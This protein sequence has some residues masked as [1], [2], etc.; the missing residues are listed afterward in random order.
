[1]EAYWDNSSPYVYFIFL[2]LLALLHPF[3][4][5]EA[6][7]F[8]RLILINCLP[9]ERLVFLFAWNRHSYL[10][11]NTH[12]VLPCFCWQVLGSP[13]QNLPTN[14]LA[15]K[16]K[17]RQAALRQNRRH[18]WTASET[19]VLLKSFSIH[20]GGRGLGFEMDCHSLVILQVMVW[21]YM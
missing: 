3:S 1:M 18:T 19:P 20:S 7:V 17:V 2:L 21:L 10:T 13:C 11:G 5:L 16:Q 4:Y 9:E 8:L 12:W 15:S 14:F 6:L